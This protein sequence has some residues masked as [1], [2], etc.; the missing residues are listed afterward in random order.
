MIETLISSK[1]RIKLLVKF[2]INS[3]NESYLRGLEDEFGES[4]NGIRLEL[5][6]FEKAGFLTSTIKGNKKYFKANT[7]HPFYREINKI[8]LKTTGIE[9]VVDYILQR[10]GDLEKVYLIGGL[11]KGLQTDIIDLVMVGEL[12]KAFLI[13]QIEKAEEKLKK[14]IRFIHYSSK[15]FRL[16]AIKQDDMFPLLLWEKEQKL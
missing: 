2:F 5:N 10:I 12:N 11:S 4:T 13:E 1:T 6:R 14:K 16:D 15:E 3:S 7:K 8:I 9:Y